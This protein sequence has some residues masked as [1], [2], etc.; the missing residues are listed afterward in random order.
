MSE[1]RRKWE[2]SDIEAALRSLG[3]EDTELL[4]PP[5]RVWD[6]IEAAVGEPARFRSSATDLQSRRRRIRRV[7]LTAA[8]VMLIAAGTAT[9]VA[10]LRGESP[11]VVATADLAHDSNT[12][13]PIGAQAHAGANLVDHGDRHTVEIVD[14]S[15]PA[16]GAGA[17]LEVWLIRPGP[18]GGVSDLV[19]L[20]VVEYQDPGSLDVPS[21]YDP[22]SYYVVDISVEPR[23][24]DSG[25]S[26]RSILRGPLHG[27]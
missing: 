10:V 25:H 24:G 6:G 7:A 20:G 13:D 5:R 18:D 23:D 17:D 19:S 3:A 9:A 11:P 8:A 4:D 15:L 22:D 21:G 14:A 2:D 1:E 27:V 12:F 16:P 26:G